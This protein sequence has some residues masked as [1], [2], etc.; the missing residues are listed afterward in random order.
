MAKYWKTT[1]TVVVL[2][3][4]DEPAIYDSLSDLARIA[5]DVNEGGCSGQITQAV[6]EEV[7]EERMAQ[8]LEVQGSEP[9][10]LIMDY[11]ELEADPETALDDQDPDMGDCGTDLNDNG[12][13]DSDEAYEARTEARKTV[14]EL[15]NE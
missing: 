1:L 13:D 9:G 10:F 7:S 8:L 5:Y 4:D 6:T 12:E 2:H 15:I 11:D 14:F 3:A